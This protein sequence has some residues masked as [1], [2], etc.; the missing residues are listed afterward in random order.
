MNVPSLRN[1][2]V[3]FG[4]IVG[5]SGGIALVSVLELSRRGQTIYVPYTVLV[6][7]LTA[8]AGLSTGLQRWLRFGLVFTGFMVASLML[9]LYI[10]LTDN[11]LA[12]SISILGHAWRLAFLVGVGSILAAAAAFV[13]ERSSRNVALG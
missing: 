12:S 3:R 13:T 10:I 5:L 2:A 7:V 9:Y 4:A 6:L 1:R 8:I 11:S